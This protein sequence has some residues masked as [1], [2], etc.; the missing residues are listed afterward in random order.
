MTIPAKY[1]N[2]VFRPLHD[3]PVKEGTVVE[4][5]VPGESPTE[6]LHSIGDSP[7]AGMWK[8]REDIAD[9]RIHE[10]PSP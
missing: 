2:G 4:V 7:F 8:D 10:S 1:E 5:Y 9:C 3:V 6:K